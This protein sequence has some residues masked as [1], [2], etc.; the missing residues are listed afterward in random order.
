MS[1]G[2]I[3]VE[4]KTR[5]WLDYHRF[6]DETGVNDKHV[7]YCRTREGKAPICA[8]LSITHFIDDRLEGPSY[9]AGLKQRI[10][11]LP[12]EHE[13]RAFARHLPNVS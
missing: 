9:L 3:N 1:K 11:F 6:F 8:E 7:H 10:L 13:I 5:E 4:R 12:R 2:G